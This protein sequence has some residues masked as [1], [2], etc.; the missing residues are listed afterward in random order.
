MTQLFYSLFNLIENN[1]NKFFL[2]VLILKK[3]ILRKKKFSLKLSTPFN[4]ITLLN[5]LYSRIHA[6]GERLLYIYIYI[7]I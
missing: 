1:D 7:Y 5:T 6:R 3:K 2:I 4:T